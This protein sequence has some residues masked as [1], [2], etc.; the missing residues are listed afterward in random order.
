MTEDVGTAEILR[1]LVAREGVPGAIPAM[2]PLRAFRVAVK[3]AV[4]P[5]V[6]TGLRLAKLDERRMTLGE[7]SA[8]MDAKGALFRLN[9]PPECAGL[10]AIDPTVVHAISAVR[11]TGGLP[12]DGLPDRPVTRIDSVVALPFLTALLAEFIGALDGL[13]AQRVMTGYRIG[14]Y[15][16]DRAAALLELE[17][18]PYRL[19]SGEVTIGD[20]AGSGKISFLVLADPPRLKQ[21]QTFSPNDAEWQRRLHG[22]V[23]KAEA[24][25]EA[26]LEPLTL[27]ISV[28]RGLKPGA[29]LPLPPE[30]LAK[31]RFVT[32][33]GKPVATGRLGQLSGNRA[34]RINDVQR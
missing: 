3:K 8:A 19:F 30:A 4:Q 28:L 14:P 33:E 9:G 23:M 22:S 16:S 5:M 11:T 21:T 31:I 12:R 27:D 13:E 7:F 20:G 15:Q 1:R 10:L 6:A 25:L 17:D 34:V 26:R 2:T 24:V 29:D 32:L 18:V